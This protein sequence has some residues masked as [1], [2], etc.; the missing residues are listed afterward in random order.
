MP[1]AASNKKKTSI[2]PMPPLQPPI[3]SLNWKT[4]S[5]KKE[6][7]RPDLE[8]GNNSITIDDGDNSKSHPTT[9]LSHTPSLPS[10]DEYQR[11]RRLTQQQQQQQQQKSPNTLCS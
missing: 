9:S 4:G 3:A 11:R 10:G 1:A 5:N 2:P 7:T 8:E 6:S